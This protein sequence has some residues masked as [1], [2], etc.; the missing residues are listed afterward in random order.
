[1]PENLLGLLLR[2]F[3]NHLEQ[4]HHGY[5]Q[6][7]RNYL[8]GIERGISAAGFH[9]TEVSAKKSAPL[10]KYFLCISLLQPQLAYT[11]T[12]DNGKGSYFHKHKCA[13]CALIRTHTNSYIRN[14]LFYALPVSGLIFMPSGSKES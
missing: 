9:A 13:V 10:G 14:V 7:Y 1:M 11:G 3:L 5:V 4:F 6:R 12:K 2:G 8:Y